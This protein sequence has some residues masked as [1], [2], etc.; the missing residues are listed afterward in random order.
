MPKRYTFIYLHDIFFVYTSIQSSAT[1]YRTEIFHLNQQKEIDLIWLHVGW[2]D[3]R[4]NRICVSR[5]FYVN[6]RTRDKQKKTPIWLEIEALSILPVQIFIQ[7]GEYRCIETRDRTFDFFYQSVFIV[8]EIRR[9]LW[10]H[11]LIYERDWNE[12][13]HTS[14]LKWLA[15]FAWNTCMKIE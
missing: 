11:G 8:L 12:F 6:S 1:C 4:L 13:V 10:T 9:L 3:L 14:I 5:L 7:K 15:R 2:Y